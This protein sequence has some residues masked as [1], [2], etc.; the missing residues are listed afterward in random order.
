MRRNRIAPKDPRIMAT[1]IAVKPR[2]CGCYVPG[3]LNDVL[4]AFLAPTL[5]LSSQAARNVIIPGWCRPDRNNSFL[6][7]C[8]LLCLNKS[9]SRSPNY[10]FD[11]LTSPPPLFFRKKDTLFGRERE[12]GFIVKYAAKRIF[13]LWSRR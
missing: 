2:N 7:L 8:V 6:S 10:S 9:S 11:L 3:A 13:E 12:P 5:M 4:I 1:T